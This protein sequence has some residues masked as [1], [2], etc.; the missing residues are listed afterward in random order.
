MLISYYIIVQKKLDAEFDF[1]HLFTTYTLIWSTRSFGTLEYV[2]YIIN[3]LIPRFNLLSLTRL[4]KRISSYLSSPLTLFLLEKHCNLKKNKD[5]T[6]FHFEPIL[7][8]PVPCKVAICMVVT[9]CFQTKF[10]N[11]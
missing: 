4:D 1:Y 2:D 5:P 7:C 6:A 3:N 10:R 9:K 8:L 11:S